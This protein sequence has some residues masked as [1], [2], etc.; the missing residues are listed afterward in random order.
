MNYL[1]KTAAVAAVLG[2]AIFGANAA[3]AATPACQAIPDGTCHSW[4]TPAAGGLDLDS[5]GA[6]AATDNPVIVYR[7]S[8]G[9]RAEDWEAVAVSAG[10]ADLYDGDI[11][12]APAAGITYVN[13]EYSPAGIPSGYCMSTIDP[14]AGQAAELRPCNTTAGSYNPYQTFGQVAAGTGDGT[15]YA[16]ED[17]SGATGQLPAAGDGLYLSDPYN[18]GEGTIGHRTRVESEPDNGALAEGQLWEVNG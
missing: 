13:L 17:L 7:I 10:A 9:D 11:T 16:F 18:R 15:F 1:Q 3:S 6:R 2:A 8:F 12:L 4:D 14:A 5:L